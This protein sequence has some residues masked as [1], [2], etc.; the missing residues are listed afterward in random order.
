MATELARPSPLAGVGAVKDRPPRIYGGLATLT[1]TDDGGGVVYTD[2]G[3]LASVTPR[4]VCEMGLRDGARL[5][6]RLLVGPGGVNSR[7][8][9]QLSAILAWHGLVAQVVACTDERVELSTR[10]GLTLSL[11]AHY[12]VD[13][14][15]EPGHRLEVI[16]A[17]REGTDAEWEVVAVRRWHF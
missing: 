2:L 16:A 5:H 7:R 4:M 12:A 14:D 17:P 9:A 11:P 3:D 10:E 8:D 1:L 15:L 6:V 13:H